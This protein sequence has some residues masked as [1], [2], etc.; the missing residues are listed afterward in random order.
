MTTH[1]PLAW[2]DGQ[3]FSERFGDVYFSRD[4]GL[5]E[6]RH[7]F[8]Q[9][10]R[11]AERFAALPPGRTF[12]IGETGFGTGLNF[13]CA[14]QC[15]RQQA[16]ADARLAFVSV[17]K[18]PLT[19]RDL[20]RAL[21]LWPELAAEAR[22][23]IDDYRIVP[24][25]WQHYLFDG[26]RVSLTLIIDDAAAGLAELDGRIDAWFLDGFSPSKNPQMWSRELFEQMARH[27]AADATFATFTCAGF[28]RR[29]LEAAGFSVSKVPGFGSKREM[30]AG[31]LRA[32]PPSAWRAPWFAR[33]APAGSETSAIVIGGGIA[34]AASA[35][36][37]AA[38]GWQVA[39]IDRHAGLAREASG[40]RQGM[41]YARLSAHATPLTRLVQAGYPFT[42]RALSRYLPED[43]RVWQRSGLLQLP[44]DEAE[45]A[46]QQALVDSGLAAP[47]ARLVDRAEA[48]ALAGITLTQGGLFFPDA[49]WLRPSALVEALAAHPGITVKTGRGVL[50]LDYDP[51][52]GQWLAL[53]T[54]GPLAIGTVVVLAGAADC[55]AFD[56]ASHLPLK[57]IRGQISH[58]AATAASGALSTILCR[59]GY[60]AP[61][62]EGLHTLG[63]SFRFD[64]DDLTPSTDEHRDNLAQLERAAPALYR[65]LDAAAL[66]PATLAGRVAMR[67]TSPDYLPLVGPLAARDAFVDRYRTLARDASL[68]PADEAPWIPGVYVNVA[69]GSRG[70][71]SAPLAGEALAA[72]ITGEPA[73][74]PSSLLDALNPNRFLLRDL[75]RGRCS[76]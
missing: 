63:A 49:G 38:R 67:C 57:R 10:N 16:P 22:A 37:L 19:P 42:L 69:H 64:T 53:G 70:M 54:D 43:G 41:L 3:P 76:G 58:V 45:R 72:L 29:G 12:V 46:R 31:T 66:D 4:S 26:G 6:T 65:A 28:V 59:E 24:A 32:A 5:R 14:W 33:S 9:H 8:L 55:A 73:P 1:A 21:A 20:A 51:A 23:L 40:N 60:I 27:S 44:V 56:C 52:L 61:A 34:G 7:V 15:F 13:L 2:H 71:V 35:A 74:L 39:L 30:C 25:G 68:K 11:L 75:I 48:T 36:A 62:S 47:F 50:E 18:Y 17:E